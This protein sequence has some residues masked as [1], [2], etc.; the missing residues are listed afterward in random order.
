MNV[1]GSEQRQ[2]AGCFQN[3]HKLPRALRRGEI[4]VC[5]RNIRF[6]GRKHVECRHRRDSTLDKP[7]L[8]S[9]GSM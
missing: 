7:A 4:P 8:C 6:S 2:V 5:L 1:D 9:N 3:S